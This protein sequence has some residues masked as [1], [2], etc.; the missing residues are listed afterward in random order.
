MKEHKDL[1]ADEEKSVKHIVEVA[2]AG[3]VMFEDC[4][5]DSVLE[6]KTQPDVNKL[7]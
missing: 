2:T 3:F 1:W 7:Q 5:H 6:I 4:W